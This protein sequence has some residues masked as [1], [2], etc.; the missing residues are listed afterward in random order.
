MY[1][2]FD[3]RAKAKNPVPW[4]VPGT[5]APNGEALTFLTWYLGA[6][7]DYQ[8]WQAA[9][10]GAAFPGV[11]LAMLYPGGE[12]RR[13]R[14]EGGVDWRRPN[15]LVLPLPPG[16]SPPTAASPSRQP[17]RSLQSR[18]RLACLRRRGTPLLRG[19]SEE[20][21]RPWHESGQQQQQ[22][23]TSTSP[24]CSARA[25]PRAFVPR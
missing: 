11:P 14:Y 24:P 3:P 19:K 23:S 22:S 16:P 8:D 18:S 9:V 10:A 2:A 13:G 20:V 12:V 15:D 21:R 17:S 7:A 25:S 4:W 6:M 1:W 5:P